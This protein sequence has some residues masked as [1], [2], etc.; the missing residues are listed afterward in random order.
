MA[1]NFPSSPTEGQVH[2]V[3]PGV[4][5]V[6]QGGAWVPAPIK[7]ALPKNYVVNPSMMVS[8]QNGD[9]AS[10][11]IASMSYYPA[12]TWVISSGLD[13][14]ARVAGRRG[15]PS[16]TGSD[17][18]VLEN[19]VAYTDPEPMPSYVQ[20]VTFIEGQRCADFGW[21]TANAKQGIFRFSFYTSLAGT[22]TVQ[23]KRAADGNPTFLAPFTAAYGAWQVFE[24]VVPP[25]TSGVWP[26]DN[27]G[28]IQL[29]LGFM[30]GSQF[31][32]GVAGWQASNKV[33]MLATD[34][35]LRAV[36]S[37]I[38]TDVG[39]Y[40]DPYK[41]GVAPPFKRPDYAHELRRCQRYWYKQ[42]ALRGGVSSGTLIARAGGVHPA[43]MR[44]APATSIVGAPRV[45]D[46][47]ATGVLTSLG[48][49]SNEFAAEMDITAAGGT[50]IGGRAGVQYWQ[51]ENQYIAMNARM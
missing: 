17:Y 51:D 30:A 9:A 6:Y 38:L 12:D 14:I 37:H 2:N 48:N 13:A 15:R 28:S 1:I 29:S 4:S 20:M 39:F 18:I 8:Q 21:G 45:W 11:P 44:A 34:N 24:I 35:G 27:T 41:T 31:A 7:T 46:A 16:D 26:T 49:V 22:Y 25:P 40:P 33:T 36:G 43:P 3:S 19:Q 23:I 47:Q 10:V 50:W 5:F 42:M 32:N